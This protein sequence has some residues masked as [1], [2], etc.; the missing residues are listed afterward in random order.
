MKMFTLFVLACSQIPM[1][2][3]SHAVEHDPPPRYDND[4]LLKQYPCGEDT[5]DGPQ[6]NGFNLCP[7]TVLQPG[8][9]FYIYIYTQSSRSLS[10]SLARFV[11]LW[12]IN[13]NFAIINRMAT[14]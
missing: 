4:D 6:Y 11:D 13:P 14:S 1:S 5:E 10:L 7:T 8:F 9:Q 12:I 3:E 2:V